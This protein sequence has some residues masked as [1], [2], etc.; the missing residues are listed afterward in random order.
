MEVVSRKIYVVQTPKGVMIAAYDRRADAEELK[1][2]M[3]DGGKIVTVKE[4]DL[5]PMS[6]MEKRRELEAKQ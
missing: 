5:F 3:A 6:H 2:W 1:S 4:T